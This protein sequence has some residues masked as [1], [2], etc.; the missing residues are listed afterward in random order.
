M[1]RIHS[2]SVEWKLTQMEKKIPNRQVLE[3]V[4]FVDR[5]AAV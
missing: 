1:S 2:D 3:M 5:G 4:F